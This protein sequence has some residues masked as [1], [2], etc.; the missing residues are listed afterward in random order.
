MNV[1]KIAIIGIC[2]VFVTTSLCGILVNADE[3]LV[4]TL[5]SNSGTS[6]ISFWY[7]SMGRMTY[8]DGNAWGSFVHFTLDENTGTV[9]DYTVKL[10]FYPNIYYSPIS[11]IAP[12][13]ENVNEDITYQDRTIF[14]SIQIS[15]FEPIALP[16]A[17]ADYLIFQGKNTLMR[18]YDSEGGSM[19]FASSS[20]PTKIIFEVPKGFEISQ[21]PDYY[22][23]DKLPVEE[24]QTG[25]NS[26]KG[27][28]SQP[29]DMTIE[30]E[31]VSYGNVTNPTLAM[32]DVDTYIQFN[33]DGTF[34]GNVGCNS[35]GGNYEVSEDD[36]SFDSVFSTM[37]Y[38]EN[39]DGQEQGVLNVFSQPDLT[40]EMND[41]TLTITNGIYMLNLREKSI[42]VPTPDT[43]TVSYPWQTIWIKSDNVTTTISSYNGTLTINGQTV[44]VDLS[45][46]GYLDVYTYVEYPAPPM[47]NDF[48]YEDLDITQDQLII[49]E[50]KNN[51]IISAE[52]WVTAGPMDMSLNVEQSTQWDQVKMANTASNNYYTYNDPTFEMTFN[53]INENGVDIVVNSEIST[54]RIVIINVD[55]EVIQNTSVEDLLVSIDSSKIYRMTAL[56]DLMVK[57]ENKDVDGAYYALSG[58]QLTTVFVYIPHFST[59]TISITTLT[60]GISVVTNLLLP[61]ILSMLFICLFIGGILVKKR[62]QNDEF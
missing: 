17:F 26:E 36:I 38:C 23:Y 4:A 55:K 40:F 61:I 59:H 13:P 6:D 60:S 3:L 50:A 16:N 28:S 57:V 33:A 15:G 24:P 25:E 42:P 5:D 46:Y 9:S 30:W 41:E 21:F 2:L 47:V 62:R 18:F 34:N 44:E 22:L 32:L 10:T 49:E 29:L 19:N 45:A 31:L 56:E 8:S 27:F 52:G 1:K 11:S 14:S 51:G 39:T 7:P 43:D 35:F 20:Q 58:E 37:M 54:G 12:Y 53:S 48:W